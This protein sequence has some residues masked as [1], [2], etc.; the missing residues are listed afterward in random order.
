LAC[1]CPVLAS[2]LAPLREA[3]GAAAE[4]CPVGDVEAWAAA[5]ARLDAEYQSSPEQWELRRQRA[6]RHALSY[7]WT[8]N[9]KRTISVYER[10]LGQAAPLAED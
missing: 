3:G 4:Y 7:T 5:V 9:A 8:E 6:R 10:V 1:G 2:D